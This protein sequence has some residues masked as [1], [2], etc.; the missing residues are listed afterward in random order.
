[1]SKDDKNQADIKRFEIEATSKVY[2]LNQAC[3]NHDPDSCCCNLK[4]VPIDERGKCAGNVKVTAK[5][6]KATAKKKK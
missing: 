2:C 5:K 4:V 1:M 3:F 6:K